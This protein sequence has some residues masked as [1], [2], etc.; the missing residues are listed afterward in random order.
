MIN[1]VLNSLYSLNFPLIRIIVVSLYITLPFKKYG[2]LDSRS[3]IHIW[4]S[5][6]LL[7]CTSIWVQRF[8]VYQSVSYWLAPLSNFW[9]IGRQC[10]RRTGARWKNSI[11][12]SSGIYCNR[13]RN[14][15]IRRTEL[16]LF[17][18]GFYSNDSLEMCILM[19]QYNRVTFTIIRR[20][21]S[22]IIFMS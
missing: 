11:Y 17:H 10:Q 18:Y 9:L 14:I 8:F 16:L 20:N 19:V 4:K 6:Y 5:Q 1:G 15:Y 3:Y 13:L 12:H 21:R 22:R 7:K 2:I